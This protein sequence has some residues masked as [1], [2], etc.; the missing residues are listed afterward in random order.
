MIKT[1]NEKWM[2]AMLVVAGIYNIIWG[3]LVIIFPSFWF[4]LAGMEL[5]NY[6]QLWQL[7]G[8]IA[9]VFGIGYLIASSNPLRHWPIILVGLL[10]KILGPIGFLYSYI[11]GSVPGDAFH[12][13]L[14]NDIIWWIPLGYILFRVYQENYELDSDL[15]NM[16][17]MSIEE[18]L[19]LY[20]TTEDE[21]LH[22]VS[23]QQPVMMVF[24]RHL[25]CTFCR[26]ALSQIAAQRKE[27]EQENT[28]IALVYQV[29]E[30]DA[31]PLLKKYGLTNISGISDPEGLL[32]K[33]FKLKRGTIPQL[34]HP[35]VIIRGIL[36]LMHGYGI[37]EEMG[38]VY[39]MPGVFVLYKGKVV[40]KFIHK[41]AADIPP[42]LELAHCEQCV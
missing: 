23:F 9:F 37:G 34:F 26:E 25:G 39:Q 22:K 8:M 13:H 10:G 4:R 30:E 35:K 3:I 17:E 5:P 27:I 31:F 28:R 12:M 1:R 40:K 29:T 6:P 33:G 18:M 36:G 38:D 20:R 2:T 7:I 41:T 19:D 11:Q 42:Y 15:I 21:S 14:T 24:L 16:T 32:Y